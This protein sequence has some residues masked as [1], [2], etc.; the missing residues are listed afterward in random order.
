MAD[1]A[2]EPSFNDLNSYEKRY[3]GSVIAFLAQE[4][5]A[6]TGQPMY[7]THL[8][9]YLAFLNKAIIEK[10][11]APAVPLTFIAMRNG[12]VPLELYN[13]RKNLKNQF[14]RFQPDIDSGNPEAF[15]VLAESPPDYTLFSDAEYVTLR[16]LIQEYATEFSTTNDI[17]EASHEKINAWKAA[18]QRQPN[19]RM[20]DADELTDGL[21]NIERLR[22]NLT[23]SRALNEYLRG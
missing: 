1:M 17:S 14:F 19:S 12:P 7:Q 13:D 5:K 23:F 10:L 21:E 18:Y 22:D 15:I 11:G 16:R 6:R 8:Y 9:K 2:K 4:H 20:D 3:L